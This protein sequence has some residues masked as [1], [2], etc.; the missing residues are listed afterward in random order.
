ML[1]K[2]YQDGDSY[3]DDPP[4]V[5]DVVL[6]R[7]VGSLFNTYSLPV[8]IHITLDH[9]TLHPPPPQRTQSRDHVA[10]TAASS[11]V[12]LLHLSHKFV[13]STLC[14]GWQIFSFG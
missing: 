14:I 6:G 4:E 5:V 8:P 10:H 9:S 12:L 11:L 7:V 2:T 1:Y 3:L 13:Q